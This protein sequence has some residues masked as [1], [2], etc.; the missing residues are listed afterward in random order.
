MEK[1]YQDYK[2]IAGICIVYISEAHAL[3]D[4]YPV[5][6]AKKLGLKEHTSLG[7]RCDAAARLLKDKKLTIPCLID[8]MDGA[9]EKAYHAW[10]DRIYLI[11]KDSKLVIAGNRG[12]WGFKPALDAVGKWLAEYKR[13][14][15]EP[16]PVV[17]K[18]PRAGLRELYRKMSEAYRNGDHAEALKLSLK[19][20]DRQPDDA[21]TI[22][23]IA[24]LHALS[25]HAEQAYTWLEKAI[26][27]GYD[28]AE[29]MLEDGDFKSIRDSDRFE[30]LV[31]R[32]RRQSADEPGDSELY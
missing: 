21:G 14:G 9:A 17:I 2:D 13:T 5:R 4:P 8:N 18:D 26:D 19:I 3:D 6:Y 23:N 7:Q 16:A 29:H 27:A 22:Y 24:C 32:A 1:L 20:L 31:E 25:G 28:D 10:P 15:V 12:P 30:K 11:G